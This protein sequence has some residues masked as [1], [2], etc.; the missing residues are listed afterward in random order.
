M[1]GVDILPLPNV[2][3]YRCVLGGLR[4]V[5]VPDAVRVWNL[6]TTPT[7]SLGIALASFMP[8]KE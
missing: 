1:A 2:L 8:R 5:R 7:G 6:A 3:Y 4:K